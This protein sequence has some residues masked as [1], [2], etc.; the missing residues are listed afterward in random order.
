LPEPVAGLVW[1]FAR[2]VPPLILLCLAYFF[3]RTLRPGALPLIERIARQGKPGLS[4]PLRRYTRRLTA[5]W[6]G[7]FIAAALCTA[8]A[9]PAFA[10]V[11]ALVWAGTVVLFVGERWLRPRFFPTEE[12]PGLLQ[13]LR[14]T[15]S[16]WR[17]RG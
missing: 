6:C 16:V 2:F 17:S 12:F 13:Q 5:L 14:D 4:E 3:G 8:T 10:Q 9:G 1:A 15:L 11:N 7:Y